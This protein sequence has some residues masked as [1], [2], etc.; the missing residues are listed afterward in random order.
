MVPG[1]GVVLLGSFHRRIIREI[2]Y[3]LIYK[4]YV[5]WKDEF[6]TDNPPGA[7]I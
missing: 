5:K 2:K 7:P 6:T 4:M 1:G 3:N